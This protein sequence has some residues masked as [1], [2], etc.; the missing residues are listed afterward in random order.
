MRIKYSSVDLGD[1][2]GLSMTWYNVSVAA[3]TKVMF[4]LLDADDNEAWSGEVSF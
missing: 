1:H 2:S 3:G 4:S